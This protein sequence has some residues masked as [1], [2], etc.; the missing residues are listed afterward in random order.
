VE[1]GEPVFELE[2]RGEAAKQSPDGT[3]AWLS[4]EVSRCIS[5]A[6]IISQHHAWIGVISITAYECSWVDT[7]LY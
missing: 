5:L 6:Y 4:E 7:L 2:G 1:E 3:L